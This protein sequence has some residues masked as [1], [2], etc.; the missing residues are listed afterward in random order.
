MIAASEPIGGAATP[1]TLR[2]FSGVTRRIARRINRL[3]DNLKPLPPAYPQG[4]THA[5]ACASR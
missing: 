2:R 1:K 5:P 3:L 4:R